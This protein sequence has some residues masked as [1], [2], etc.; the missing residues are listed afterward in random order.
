MYGVLPK[1]PYD[2]T[3]TKAPV[4]CSVLLEC[5]KIDGG[6]HHHQHYLQ[7]AGLRPTIA[8]AIVLTCIAYRPIV[9]VNNDN[10]VYQPHAPRQLPLFSK[11]VETC[12]YL[13]TRLRQ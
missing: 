6:C 4:Q 8:R 12:T 5:G 13:Y 1:S 9:Q 11:S 3:S 7:E 2:L 10:T